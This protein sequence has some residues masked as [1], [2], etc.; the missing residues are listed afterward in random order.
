MI[1]YLTLGQVL[2]LHQKL[3]EQS[4][5]TSGIHDPNALESA[6]A[7]PKM[8]FEGKEL[9]PTL[10]EKAAALCYSLINNHPFVDGNKRIGHAAMEV[11][12]VINGYEIEAAS[13]EQEEI[14]LKLASSKV[15]RSDFLDWLKE[16]ISE[17]KR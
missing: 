17:I 1:Q 13:G 14:I 15:E 5:G 11:F 7:Q 8:T 4:G 2:F 6:L 3:I 9:Y 10:A 16:N 12:L